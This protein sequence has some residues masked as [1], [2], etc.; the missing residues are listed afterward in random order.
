[1]MKWKIEYRNDQSGGELRAT[2][3][4]GSKTKEEV[5]NFLGLDRPDVH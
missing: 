1:M 2:Y 5:I 4:Y 3:Y